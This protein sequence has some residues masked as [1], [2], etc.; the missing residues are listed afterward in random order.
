MKVVEKNR[1]SNFELLRIIAMFAIT[2]IHVIIHGCV[3]ENVSGMTQTVLVF[4]ECIVYLFVNTFILIAGYYQC[5]NTFKLKNL[6]RINNAM[7]FYSVVI[8]GI[9]YIFNLWPLSKGELIE[10]ALPIQY[11]GAWF[12][13]LY[14]I[15]Y[16]VSPVL[17]IIIEKVNQKEHT[18]LII[19]GLL[20][21]SFLPTLTYQVTYNNAFGFSLINFIL[22]Y[23][24]GAYFRKYS[25]DKSRIME[26][27]S[28]N[29]Q[30][31]IIFAILVISIVFNFLLNRFGNTFG[32]SGLQGE[33]R[34]ILSMETF[35]YDNPLV[36]L[37]STCIFLLFWYKDFSSK[38]CN[39]IA[40]LTFGIYLIHDNY[41][42][43]NFLYKWFGFATET[44]VGYSNGSGYMLIIKI[45]LTA[46]IVFVGCAIIEYIRQLIFKFIYNRKFSTAIR[47]KFYL[48]IK[49]F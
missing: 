32:N 12:A 35:S 45:F 17:N 26:V 30:K 2:V 43:N 36:I 34:K 49:S 38:L 19:V 24:I 23:F 31:F 10:A 41:T 46:M 14:L 28:K 7:W 42:L 29:K 20:L 5:T 27:Y 37:G 33:L 15:L 6:F 16:C 22:L 8:L 13:K 9:I 1:D 21:F 25:I 48:F 4:L 11:E 44:N 40:G 3:I 47:E 39:K 18:K